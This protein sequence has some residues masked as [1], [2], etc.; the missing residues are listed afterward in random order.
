MTDWEERYLA[1]DMP[2]E[3]GKAAPPLL[4]LLGKM[5][6]EQWGEGPVL[7]PG[8][9]YGHDVRVLAAALDAPILGLDLSPTAV[10]RAGEFPATGRESYELGDFLDPAWPGGRKFSAVWEHTCFCAID[11]SRRDDYAA[12][13]AR[14]IE[15]GGLLAGV[16]F[17]TPNDP[18]EEGQGPPFNTS[19]GEL[20]TRFAP[21]FSRLDGWV[22]GVA[23]PGREGREWIGLFRREE[24]A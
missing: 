16:F 9:G 21:W 3:K 5:E 8:C 12:A 24:K 19:I 11:P 23:Y 7:V 20:E 10:E 2:W 6:A 1:N 4:E 22:P 17:L 18:G 15:P 14:C 13:V